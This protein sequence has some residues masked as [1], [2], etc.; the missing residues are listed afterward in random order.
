MKADKKRKLWTLEAHSHIH[1][2]TVVHKYLV[3]TRTIIQVTIRAIETNKKKYRKN[4]S[5]KSRSV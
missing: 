1:K 5:S 3:A 4:T 2:R